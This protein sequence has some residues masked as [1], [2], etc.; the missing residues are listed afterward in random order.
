MLDI[1]NDS[2][3]DKKS[4]LNLIKRRNNTIKSILTYSSFLDKSWEKLDQNGLEFII[5]EMENTEANRRKQKI[6][7]E[8]RNY[9]LS[10]STIINYPFESIIKLNSTRGRLFVLKNWENIIDHQ[11][12]KAQKEYSHVFGFKNPVDGSNIQNVFFPFK[13]NFRSIP[14]N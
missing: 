6:I 9:F 13:C 12:Y 2:D 5:R 4:L 8:Q 3:K 10:A 11:N 7:G 1:E 14:R